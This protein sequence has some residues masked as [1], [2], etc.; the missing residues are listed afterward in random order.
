MVEIAALARLRERLTFKQLLDRE[1]DR[2][3]QSGDPARLAAVALTAR[4]RIDRQQVLRLQAIA[5]QGNALGALLDYV[6]VQTGKR[7]EWRQDDFGRRLLRTLSDL[8]APAERLASQLGAPQE[9]DTLAIDI[10]K[11][12]CRRFIRHF[13]A[14]YLLGPA[15]TPQAQS[16]RGP[17]AQRTQ[18]VAVPR[19]AA[20]QRRTQ[21]PPERAAEAPAEIPSPDGPTA[22]VAEALEAPVADESSDRTAEITAQQGDHQ[23]SAPQAELGREE[24]RE[25][26]S[27]AVAAGAEHHS[28]VSQHE[29]VAAEKIEESNVAQP[30][31]QTEHSHDTAK[32][33]EA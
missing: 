14:A 13:V 8:E 28:V 12:L 5:E 27:G 22:A 17:E 20:P 25:V 24:P 2:L 29:H 21:P 18:V 6:Q 1:S 11:E 19:S 16:S 30:D 4:P 10:H 23:D 3:Y 7:A 15:P 26:H 9:G 32:E 33:S 31:T